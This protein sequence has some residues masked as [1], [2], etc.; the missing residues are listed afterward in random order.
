ML[1]KSLQRLAKESS[2]SSIT[3]FGK[4]RGTKSDY[5]IA[6]TTVDG[7]D[8]GGEDGEGQDAD[9]PKDADMEEKGSGVNKFT[10]FVTENS[11]S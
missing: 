1:Q 5:Y 4:I 8:D 6:E 9:E 2:A 10:Y 3:F 11:F 7:G